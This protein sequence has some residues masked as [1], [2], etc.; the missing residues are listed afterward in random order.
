M[1]ACL[2]AV[3]GLGTTLS[4]H[5]P[6]G[7]SDP[8]VGEFFSVYC[9]D[10]HGAVAQGG[11]LNLQDIDLTRVDPE[12]LEQWRMIDHR[13]RFHDMPPAGARQP[14]AAERQAV[15][16][17]IRAGL[18]ATQ[19]PGTPMD[20]NRLLPEYGN[21]VDHDALF[22]E[23]AGPVIPAPAGL[24]RIRP[25]IYSAEAGR[26]ADTGSLSQPF[27][28]H[29]KPGLQDYAPLYFVDEPAA[30]QLLH[31]AGRLVSAQSA[32]QRYGPVFQAL[33]PDRVP[34]RDLRNRALVSQFQLALR[35]APGQEEAQRYLSLWQ[36]NVATSGHPVGSSA[37]LMAVLLHHETLF[38]SELGTGEPDALGRLRL[39]QHEIARGITYAL[40][41]EF[42]PVIW[43]AAGQG[44]LATKSQIAEH[45]ERL[46]SAPD[47]KNPR[48]LQFF[49]EY[50]DYARALTVFK[51]APA[52]GSHDAAML[53]NDLE[54]LIG[55]ILASDRQVLRSL[56]TTDQAFVNW[57][58]DEDGKTAVPAR[59][60]IGVETVY[61]LSP[62]WKWTDIQ[63]ITLPRGHRAGVLT[64]PAWLVAWSGNF[65]NDPVRRGWWIRSRLLGGSVPAVP[66]GVDAR[67]PET[68]EQT[69]RERVES[70]TRD[71]ACWRCHVRMNPLGLPFEQYTHY[72][73]F[74]ER[75][76]GRAV[77]ASGIID[78]TGDPRLDGIKV[79][80]PMSMVRALARS[81]RVE[82]VFVRHVF[83]YFLGRNET[84]GDAATLQQA[85]RDYRDSG[86]S[87]KSLVKSLLTSDSFLYRTS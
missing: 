41:D 83:R 64:H 82:Q 55:Y 65:D 58:V 34:D 22:N 5:A 85:W 51:D 13:L 73:Y 76:I 57:H 32:D 15:L 74:R 81:E 52:R 18:L 87:F 69:L 56:L 46:L 29:G 62:D 23:P 9:R 54:A 79:Q 80:D 36:R 12:A 40:R 16:A 30:D 27:T 42:E 39:S 33:Q 45:L 7:D 59:R 35:R 66:V 67:I 14:Q 78:R 10:C 26:N 75:E 86:G 60:E 50:F 8:T 37:T 25:G 3:Q 48:L 24:W 11:G 84:L 63:P 17:W 71:P 43:E 49:R 38:R 31:N 1:L 72:G 21:H 77:D 68:E 61:G 2:F 28:L 4:P 47:R 20:S 53:V 70:V 19:R 6:V 44:K